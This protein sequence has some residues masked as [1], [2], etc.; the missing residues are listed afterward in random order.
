[1]TP[2]LRRR[3]VYL[4]VCAIILLLWIRFGQFEAMEAPYVGF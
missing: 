4:A 1:M 3:A 2:R